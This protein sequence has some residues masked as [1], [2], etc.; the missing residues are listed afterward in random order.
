MGER[1]MSGRRLNIE[2]R[3]LSKRGRPC[4]LVGLKPS[5][6]RNFGNEA[7]RA[8]TDLGVNGCVSRTVRDTAAWLEATQ[9]RDPGAAFAPVPFVIAPVDHKPRVR[10]YSTVMRTGATPD[11]GVAR[12]FA[13]TVGLLGRLGHS[14]S[15]GRLPFDGPKTIKALNDFIEGRFT[16]QLDVLSEPIGIPIAPEDLEH[17]SAMLVAAGKRID[18]ARFVA[19]L[20]QLEEAVAACLGSLNEFDIWMTPTLS[21]E[22]VRI[23]AFGP[24]IAWQ[25]QRNHLVDYA[26]YCWIDNFAGTPSISLPWVFPTT[27]CRSA[28]NLPRDPAVKQRCLPWLINSRPL[29]NGGDTSRRSGWAMTDRRA[30]AP[31]LTQHPAANRLWNEHSSLAQLLGLVEPSA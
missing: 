12:V 29:W 13:E 5:R 11:A 23:G 21:T 9:T 19:A 27:E 7:M 4:G 18:D 15:E 1:A 14:V 24:D 3:D 16:R 26:G 20:R 10:S 28:C 30:L 2:P 17:H 31:W 8:V 6:G 25:D 22:I